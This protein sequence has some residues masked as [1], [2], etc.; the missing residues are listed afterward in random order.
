MPDNLNITL[1]SASSLNLNL[2]SGETL[3]INSAAPVASN[4]YERLLNQPQI[5]GVTLIGNQTPYDIGLISE[6]TAA[7]W[8]SNPLYVPKRGEICLYTDT[9]MVKI[10][11]GSVP[12]V[13]LPYIRSGGIA[14]LEDR[15]DNHINSTA[16]HVSELDRAFWDSKLNYRM[17]DETLILNRN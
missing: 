7:G 12:I 8:A 9:D 13:D 15:I 10:G 17:S 4:N 16:K 11:D 14:E 1:E 2:N 3:N 5:N 6:N